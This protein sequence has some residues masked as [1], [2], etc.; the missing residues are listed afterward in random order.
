MTASSGKLAFVTVGTTSFDELI[1]VVDSDAFR[2]ALRERGFVRV[3]VQI[4]RG[5][6][7]PRAGGP[8]VELEFY[9]FK[10]S[11]AEDYRAASLVISHAG[12]GSIMESLELRLPLIVIVNEALMDNHQIELAAAMAE[13]RHCVYAFPRTLEEAVR[14]AGLEALE[15]LPP[16][17]LD[18]FA[19]AVDAETGLGTARPRSD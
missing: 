10:P 18:A 11:L 13:R 15:P 19:R 5:A 14:G 17:A 12:A 16:R 6:F 1:R 3:L 9:R 7:E 8:E 4:G 2:R